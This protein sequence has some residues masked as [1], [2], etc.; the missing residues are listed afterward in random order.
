[1]SK[2]LQHQTSAI[3]EKVQQA[4]STL[5]GAAPVFSLQELFNFEGF[6]LD[7]YCKVFSP[8]PQIHQLLA[9]ARAFGERFGIWLPNAEHYI[10]CAI[11]L[12]PN[13]GVDRMKAIVRNLAID[14]FLNDTMGRDIFPRL[15]PAEQEA[16]SRVKE[17]MFNMA[18][19]LFIEEADATPVELANVKV[20]AFMRDTSPFSWFLEFLRLY[21]YHIYVAHKDCNINAA[22]RIASIDEY[23]DSRCHLSGM[24]HVISL[25]EYS[26]GLFL[27][28]EWLKET[29]IDKQLQRLHYTTA[30]IGGLMNDLFSFEKEVIDNQADS[31]LVMIILH[32]K[33]R[34]SLEGAI[35]NAAAIVRSQLIEFVGLLDYI[36]GEVQQYTAVYPEKA[37]VMEAHFRGLER[38]VQAS[39]IWQVYTKRYKSEYSIFRETRLDSMLVAG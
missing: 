14:Y 27:D 16:A 30:A 21:S 8:H 29:G 32:N 12:F 38:C 7:E 17:R 20:L 37:A 1:M 31:N 10:S 25:V 9:D 28:W 22:G 2:E 18:A 11:Y 24:H 39:W 23:I 35:R 15:A 5:T 13:A 34:L 26:E 36:K 33:P 6:R 4:Y 3:L 19:D